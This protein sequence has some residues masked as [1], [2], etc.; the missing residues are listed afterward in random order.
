MKKLEFLILFFTL[1]TLGYS[2]TLDSVYIGLNGGYT[3]SNISSANDFGIK[4]DYKGGCLAGLYLGL[5]FKTRFSLETDINFYQ[6]GYTANHKELYFSATFAAKNSYFGYKNQYTQNYLKNAWLLGYSI[7]DKIEFA[8]Q[9]GAYWAYLINSKCDGTTF[10]IVDPLESANLKLPAG[11][12][13]IVEKG[14]VNKSEFTPFDIGFVGGV[15]LGYKLNNTFKFVFNARYNRG[16]ID[17]NKQIFFSN[18]IYTN[19]FSFSFGLKMKLQSGK[20]VL[21]KIGV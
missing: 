3:H 16:V 14:T 5:K 19:S 15:G 18:T 13:E 9:A 1:S 21:N 6:N 17:S 11:Y 8:I 12:H 4:C 20:S 10:T 7:G 2:Q